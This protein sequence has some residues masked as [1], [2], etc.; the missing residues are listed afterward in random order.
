MKKFIVL[1]F[2][3]KSNPISITLL[4][5]FFLVYIIGNLFSIQNLI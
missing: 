1:R 4:R 2:V 5:N 3:T